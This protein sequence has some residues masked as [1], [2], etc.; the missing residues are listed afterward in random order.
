MA[1]DS[2]AL[3]V[4]HDSI[5]LTNSCPWIGGT[6]QTILES[7]IFGQVVSDK[8]WVLGHWPL[9]EAAPKTAELS[10]AAIGQNEQLAQHALF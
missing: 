1:T 6:A 3:T 8:V 4:T 2:N 10:Q 7:A 9:A 5:A